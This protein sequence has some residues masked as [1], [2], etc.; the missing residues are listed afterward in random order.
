MI[1]NADVDNSAAISESKLDLDYSTSSLNTAITTHTGNTSNPH[2]TT[3]SN[4]TDT[5]ITSAASGDVLSYDGSKWVNAPSSSASL[6][7]LS[8]TDIT[9]PANGDTLVYNN[10]S[11][12][13]ENSDQLSTLDST[14]TTHVGSTSNP[15]STS[16]SNLTDT[17]LSGLN[18]GDV[19]VYDGV[20]EWNNQLNELSNI[21]DTGII[22]PANGDALVYDG[23]LW[24]N[25]EN[26]IYNLTDTVINS[27]TDGDILVYDSNDNVWN[28]LENSIDNLSNVD[29]DSNTETEND[30][31]VYDDVNQ[32]WINSQ[33]LVN[34]I[35]NASNP[36]LTTV[37][38]LTDTTITTPAN[39][40]V[41][42]YDYANSQW[43]NFSIAGVINNFWIT[44]TSYSVGDIVNYAGRTYKCVVAHTSSSG[45]ETDY[46]AGKWDDGNVAGTIIQNL[47]SSVP[48]HYFD[49]TGNDAGAEISKTTYASLYAVIGDTYATCYNYSGGSQ[50]SAPASGNFRLPD[51]RDTYFKNSGVLTW[52]AGHNASHTHK[53][54]GSNTVDLSHS[55]SIYGGNVPVTNSPTSVGSIKIPLKNSVIAN[56][57]EAYAALGVQSGYSGLLS[58][59]TNPATLTV[60]ALDSSGSGSSPEPNYYGTKIFLKY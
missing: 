58:S 6:S 57:A 59:S 45:F 48:Y 11:T 52:G 42:Y 8:D 49:V 7:G 4:L 54:N 22:S 1:V 36:H 10:V 47:A 39:G 24:I 15:H 40:D 56:P 18:A 27:A 31:L 3:V 13:W 17:S 9:T 32:K 37:S 23:N 21:V 16:V 20:S 34:H 60:P 2:S 43:I 53:Y 44:S 38:K 41:L 46:Y 35:G 28:N 5:T 51:F 50:Y 30:V 25:R 26:S 19:L 14:V 55:H 12:K 29:I 33:I